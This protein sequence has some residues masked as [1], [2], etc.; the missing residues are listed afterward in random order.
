M[1][2]Q[3]RQFIQRVAGGLGVA[4]LLSLTV[5]GMAFWSAKYTL[6][7]NDQIAQHLETIKSLGLLINGLKEAETG[8]QSYLLIENSTVALDRYGIGLL[9][10]DQELRRLQKLIVNN[11][12]Q[13]T[14]LQQLKLLANDRLK[15]LKQGIELYQKKQLKATTI[16]QSQ[17]INI[18]RIQ[19]L[20]RE[21]EA[22]L[23]TFRGKM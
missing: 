4:T 6:E 17:E 23:F 11:S 7:T 21:M 22:A 16:V 12:M 9:T 13:A 8:Q 1:I 10:V 15:V 14:S 2:S 19:W 3:Y 20:V 18:D 5:S